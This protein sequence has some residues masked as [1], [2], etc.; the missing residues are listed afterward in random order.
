[1]GKGSKKEAGAGRALRRIGVVGHPPEEVLA[2]YRA[3]GAAFLD[4]DVPRPEA[5]I[6]LA[7]PYLPRPFCATLRTVLAN[8]LSLELDLIV[9]GVGECKCD[10]MRFLARI[11]R[12]LGVR[13]VRETRNLA[14]AGAGT[15]LCDGTGP[16]RRRVDAILGRI[17]SGVRTPPPPLEPD[18]P[19][20]FWGVPPCDA[21]LLDLFPDGTQILGWTRAVEND[22]PADLETET[23]VPDGLP[24]VF[25]AQ[26]FCQKTALA[27]FLARKHDGLYVDVD[28][29]VSRAVRAKVEAYLALSA[30]VPRKGG[31]RPGPGPS[32]RARST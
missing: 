23:F 29:K 6:R 7:D 16:L 4:L 2:A 5:P 3:A 9:A 8:A 12:D 11:L 14:S 1:M 26:S 22:T 13:A 25:F 15:P 17:L 10:G 31:G 24:T 19:A 20:G 21:S 32:P 27:R 30:G 18:P 28:E